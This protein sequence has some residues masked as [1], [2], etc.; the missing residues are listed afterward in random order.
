MGKMKTSEQI[1]ERWVWIKAVSGLLVAIFFISSLT[2][3]VKCHYDQYEVARIVVRE[4]PSS[5]TE[6]SVWEATVTLEDG[7]ETYRATITEDSRDV[8]LDENG[9]PPDSIIARRASEEVRRA[10]MW[11]KP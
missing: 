8:W 10:K 6:D 7:V 11:N 1:A 4:V 3:L 2:L 9:E 5:G